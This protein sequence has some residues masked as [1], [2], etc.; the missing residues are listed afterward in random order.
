MR[1]THRKILLDIL[2]APTA[3]FV[4]GAVIAYLERFCRNR[5]SLTMT[6]DRGG[7]VMVHLRRGRRRVRRP[8][9]LTAHVDHPGFIADRMIGPKKL[10]AHWRGGVRPEYFVGSAVRFYAEGESIRGQ[11][12]STKRHREGKIERVES[13]VI[14]VAKPVPPGAPGMWDL[15]KASIR[16]GRI[17]ARACDDLIGVAAMVCAIEELLRGT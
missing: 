17:R 14:D 10:R 5:R 6:R 3:P 8:V 15:A 12:R 13:A 16:G 2:S 1:P 11:V 9:C 4:D 7:N